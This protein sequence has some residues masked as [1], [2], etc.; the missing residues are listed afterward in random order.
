LAEPGSISN[1]G[2]DIFDVAE[3]P[4]RGGLGVVTVA[5]NTVFAAVTGVSIASA[6]MFTRTA[7]PAR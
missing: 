3:T 6:A 2:K 7:V 5:A 1:V 4:L